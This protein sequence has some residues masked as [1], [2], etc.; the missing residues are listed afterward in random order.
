MILQKKQEVPL[1]E[2]KHYL[3]ET[4]SEVNSGTECLI[5][6]GDETFL[7]CNYGCLI[8]ISDPQIRDLN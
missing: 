6:K 7:L 8:S 2:N 3:L 4:T 5:E 1:I